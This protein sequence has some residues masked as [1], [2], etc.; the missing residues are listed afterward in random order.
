[1]VDLIPFANEP[2]ILDPRI[3]SGDIAEG[4]LDHIT[5][6]TD[7]E[8]SQYMANLEYGYNKSLMDSANAFTAG[9]NAAAMQFNAAEAA[10]QYERS[11]ELSAAE[12]SWQSEENLKAF[13]RAEKTNELNRAFQERLSNTAYQRMVADLKAA[14]LNPYLAYAQGGAP[15][16][17]GSSAT[18]TASQG[19][20]GSAYSA[21][22]SPGHSVS[23]S[24]R[25]SLGKTSMVSQILG[26]IMHSAATLVGSIGKFFG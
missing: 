1:M 16:T 26:D 19:A 17:S 20:S 8:R 7:F 15:V 6:K 22:V 21:S 9:Q 5:G 2:S 24:V 4:L 23:S 14:G 25:A 12:R 13:E 3:A 11:K 10:K 18:M